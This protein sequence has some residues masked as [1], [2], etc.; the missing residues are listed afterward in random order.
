MLAEERDGLVARQLLAARPAGSR[1]T[2]SRIVVL[3]AREV[4]GREPL[5][6]LEVVVEAVLDHRADRDLGAREEAL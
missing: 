4:V 2:I 5:G 1:A 6:P 3:D